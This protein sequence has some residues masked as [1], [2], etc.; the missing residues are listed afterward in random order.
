MLAG[1]NYEAEIGAFFVPVHGYPIRSAP[2][3]GHIEGNVN[4]V[5]PIEDRN[6]L[7]SYFSSMASNPGSPLVTKL[8]FLMRRHK[9]LTQEA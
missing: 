1:N 2:Y 6:A 8:A 4:S 9:K 5:K 7:A 3:A